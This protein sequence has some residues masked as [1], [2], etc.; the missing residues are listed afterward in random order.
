MMVVNLSIYQQ[1]LFVFKVHGNL[2]YQTWL[3]CYLLLFRSKKN[4]MK[5]MVLSNWNLFRLLRLVIGVAI[6]VQ[7][8]LVKDSMLG[9]AGLLFTGM[10]VFNIG[11]CGAAGCYTSAKAGKTAET[12]E[13]ISYE[14]V[15]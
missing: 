7:A 6:I 15:V 2:C 8:I 14:E 4:K 10:A 11:C 12:P 3:F 5:Q 13:D 9:M 1:W